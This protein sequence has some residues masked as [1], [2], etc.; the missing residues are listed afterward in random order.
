MANK[1]NYEHCHAC[2]YFDKQELEC[3]YSYECP[4]PNDIMRA[5]IRV[6]NSNK[7]SKCPE[8]KV[9]H[10][11][12]IY[13]VNGDICVVE[14]Y[15]KCEHLEKCKGLLKMF[16]IKPNQVAKKTP[17]NIGEAKSDP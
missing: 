11:S 8:F 15:F 4:F 13:Y 3:K 9:L 10:D 6:I 1:I 7:C 12:Q 5:E 2:D 16:G 17:S 14:H